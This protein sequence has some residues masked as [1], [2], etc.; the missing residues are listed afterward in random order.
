MGVGVTT[1]GLGL[2]ALSGGG[3]GWVVL[4]CAGALLGLT[5]IIVLIVG[6]AMLGARN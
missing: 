6:L 2:L 4:I 3:L 1:A 5:G